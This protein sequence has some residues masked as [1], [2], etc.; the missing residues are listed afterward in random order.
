[1]IVLCHVRSPNVKLRINVFELFSLFF[2]TMLMIMHIPRV[3]G[4]ELNRTLVPCEVIY[5]FS[6]T[7]WYSGLRVF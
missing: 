7:G 5:V 3:A 1:M 2:R 6:P 4:S